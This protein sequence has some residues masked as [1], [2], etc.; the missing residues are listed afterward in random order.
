MLFDDSLN[1]FDNKKYRNLLK[2]DYDIIRQIKCENTYSYCRCRYRNSCRMNKTKSIKMH[3]FQIIIE[4]SYPWVTVYIIRWNHRLVKCDNSHG[5][6][7][8]RKNAKTTRWYW[9]YCT[10]VLD[11]ICMFC[12][13]LWQI[14]QIYPRKI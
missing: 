8:P 10:T 7:P 13:V 12:H 3:R 6:K 5:F 9:L 14:T 2:A 1:D 11:L 4:Y